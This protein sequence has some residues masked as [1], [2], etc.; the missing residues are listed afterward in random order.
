ML[1]IIFRWNGYKRYGEKDE[2][3]MGIL[4]CDDVV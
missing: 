1:K 2:D 4:Y 3:G